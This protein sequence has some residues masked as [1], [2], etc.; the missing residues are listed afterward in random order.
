MEHEG[1]WGHICTSKW[2]RANSHV[3]C[4]QLGFPASAES[5][6]V[7]IQDVEPVYWLDQVTCRGWE[8]SI[9]SCDHAGWG[10]HQCEDG[11][12]LRIKCFRRKITK[13]GTLVCKFTEVFEE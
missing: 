7:T 5:D 4:G 1:Q 9:V 12:V 6:A 3:L 10:P 2:T 8:S 13:V 11:G